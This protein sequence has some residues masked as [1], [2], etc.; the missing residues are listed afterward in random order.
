MSLKAINLVFVIT[1]SSDEGRD[2]VFKFLFC[3][4]VF[5]GGGREFVSR[6]YIEFLLSENVYAV[7]SFEDPHSDSPYGWTDTHRSEYSEDNS[8]GKIFDHCLYRERG[9]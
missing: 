6:L 7:T 2:F 9:V 5:L 3:F 4:F 1:H 8:S